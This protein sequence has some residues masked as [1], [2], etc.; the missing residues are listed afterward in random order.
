MF[1]VNPCGFKRWYEMKKN[2]WLSVADLMEILQTM[3][4]DA[5]V[6][7]DNNDLYVNAY[8]Y[9]T[10]D[11]IELVSYADGTSEVIIGTNYNTKAE[12]D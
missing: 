1:T 8:Y 2:Q 10:R 6:I 12:E 7:V 11:S 3:P 4:Q 5:K 9:A